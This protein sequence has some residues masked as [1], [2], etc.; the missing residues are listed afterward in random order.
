MKTIRELLKNEDAEMLEIYAEEHLDVENQENLISS[1][2][3]NI[4]ERFSS[5]VENE[6]NFDYLDVIN[7]I[8]EKGESS[9]ILEDELIDELFLFFEDDDNVAFPQELDDI[10]NKKFDKELQIK[11][12]QAVVICYMEINYLMPLDF[13]IKNY[14]EK[15]NLSI[16]IDDLKLENQYIIKDDKILISDSSELVKMY[17]IIT[18]NKDY[19][20]LTYEEL[21]DSFELRENLLKQ[22]KD[23]IKNEEDIFEIYQNLTLSIQEKPE[24]LEELLIEKYNLSEKKANK[25]SKY[26]LSIVE[27]LRFTGSLGRNMSDEFLDNIIESTIS[28]KTEEEF[29]IEKLLEINELLKTLKIGENELLKLYSSLKE[30]EMVELDM[31]ESFDVQ[32]DT[33]QA[34]KVISGLIYPI[35]VNGRLKYVM[36]VELKNIIKTKKDK[37]DALEKKYSEKLFE[38]IYYIE[39]YIDINGLISKE[40]LLSL[41]EMN[42][43]ELTMEDLEELIQ[44]ENI[45][46]YNEYLIDPVFEHEPIE[47]LIREKNKFDHYK[48]YDEEMCDLKNDIRN[49]LL[50]FYIDEDCLE[51]DIFYM[52]QFNVFNKKELNN[53]LIDHDVYLST[54][55][56]NDLYKNLKDLSEIAPLWSKNGFS[57]IECD[58]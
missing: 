57:K 12:L 10:L 41:L 54:K 37:K 27:N 24:K 29:T 20:K 56:L 38:I 53:S 50:D 7:S 58:N 11:L 4:I 47:Y 49:S 6:F 18:K 8:K 45:D 34:R 22:L 17:E 13:F 39:K 46:V 2:E 1:I 19:R 44:F 9:S 23:E 55:D 35:K 32:Y 28:V 33:F 5:F 16:T 40:K 43:I 48:I 52:I 21:V 26:Y 25:I 36:P 3:E 14:I 51:N 15:Y 42:N 31:I 30:I